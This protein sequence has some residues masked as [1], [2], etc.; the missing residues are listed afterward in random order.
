MK[1]NYSKENLRGPHKRL[2]RIFEIIPGLSSW[3]VLIGMV[4]IS[5]FLPFTGAI[6]II[7][8]YLWWLLRILYLTL[9]L[10]LSYI[11]LNI[12]SKTDWMS[13][14]HGLDDIGKYLHALDFRHGLL[15]L[16]Q[17]FSLWTHRREIRELE[18]SGKLPPLSKNIYHCVIFPILKEDMQIIEPAIAALSQQSF[19]HITPCWYLRWKNV[20]TLL[21]NT[22]SMPFVKNTVNI[23][24]NA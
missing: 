21:F 2:Q 22:M 15:T 20:P 11:R 5:I 12:E 24:L 3:T 14:V 19:R 6:I 17:R 8:F 13:R 16:R 18:L 23:F 4:I 10:I 1:F 7:C 9:F